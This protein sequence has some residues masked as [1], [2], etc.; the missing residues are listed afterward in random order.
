MGCASRKFSLEKCWGITAMM[1]PLF[2]I[3]NTNNA[4]VSSIHLQNYEKILFFLRLSIFL[5]DFLNDRTRTGTIPVSVDSMLVNI[6]KRDFTSGVL[7]DR[8]SSWAHLQAYNDTVRVAHKEQF[9]QAL[10]ELYRASLKNKFKPLQEFRQFYTPDSLQNVVDIGIINASF[11]TVNYN[12][13]NEN[14]GGLRISQGLFEKIENG[15]SA[16]LPRHVFMASPLKLNLKGENVVF[17]FGENFLLQST[18]GKDIMRLTAN[19][20]TDADYIL[21]EGGAARTQKIEIDYAE[22]GLKTLVF[23]ATFADGSSLTTHGVFNF[24]LAAPPAPVGA[25]AD[26]F[27]KATIPFQGYEESQALYGRVD[28]RIFYH[29]NNGNNEKTLLKPIVVIDGFD[30]GDKRKI[31]DSDPHPEQSDE[32]HESIYEFMSYYVGQN[33]FF[34]VPQLRSLGYDIVIVNHPTY[35]ENLVQQNPPIIDGGADYIERN[36]M[37]HVAL[38]QALNDT[39]AQNNSAEQLVIVGPSMGGQISR[40]ALAYMEKHNMPHNTRLWVSVDSP[41]LGANIPMG[42]QSLL[43]VLNDFADSAEAQDFVENQLGSAAARQQL[44]EQ[45]KVDYIPIPIPPFYLPFHSYILDGKTESQGFSQDQGH[46]FF[47]QY[48]D[49]LYNNGLPN[50][51][52][53]PQNL[54]KIAIVNG[55]L[56]NSIDFQNPFVSGGTDFNSN[57][58][59]PSSYRSHGAQ[60][61]KI[62]G[63]ANVIGHIV[64]LET[65]NLP[66]MG[67]NHKL[68]YFKKKKFGGW[69]YYDQY[70][71]NNNSRGNMDNVPGGWFPTQRELA[72]SIED[73][74]PCDWVG[75]EDPNWGGYICVN[76][77]YVINLAHVSSFIPTVSALGFKDPD[78][79]WHQAFKR[80]LVCPGNKEIPFDTY[81]GPRNNE[82]HT[83]F[84]EKS[85]NWLLEELAGNPQPPTV[86]LD[87]EDM[88]GPTVICGTDTV[89]YSFD[90]CESLPVIAWEVSNNLIKTTPLTNYNRSIIVQPVHASTNGWAYVKAIFASPNEPVQKNIWIGPPK[91]NFVEDVNITQINHTMPIVPPDS[92]DEFGLKLNISPSFGNVQQMEWEKVST[93]YQW[94]QDPPGYNDPYVII[95]PLCEDPVQFKVRM[96]NECGWSNWQQIEDTNSECQTNCGG[97]GGGSGTITSD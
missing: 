96:R 92:C 25:I 94:S 44:I 47:I 60:T 41:H 12:E 34:L 38:Y 7:Y 71:T 72:K 95:A 87:P 28:Y 2:K 65:Y 79:N 85:V 8:V 89:T 35:P 56:T 36:A 62:E 83:S 40:Y 5:N 53:Y 30:P 86:P 67:N 73:S 21:I 68:S 10:L 81:F 39:L 26:G 93:N 90:F 57:G 51:E 64:T 18:E 22:D 97:G 13:K 80:N 37:A 6:S 17:R 59:T 76:D 48:Y 11:H 77:W 43:N 63:D 20:G 61:F 3:N 75:I 45:H 15:Q 23:T 66:S 84:T 69:T 74:T 54:R 27:I 24:K 32:N 58:P 78:F 14:Q 42:A 29:T 55:S 70:I 50:S 1:P 88:S 4:I 9:E 16:F 19:F 49:A 82:Q 46:P 31:Q 91:V 33:R 52:G